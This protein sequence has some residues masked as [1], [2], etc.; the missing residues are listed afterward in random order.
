MIKKLEEISA[1]A[2]RDLETASTLDGLEQVRISVLGKKGALSE[3]LKTLGSV[4]AAERPAIGAAANEWKRKIEAAIETRKASLENAALQTQLER[5]RV[6]ISLPSRLPHRG[7][8]ES[9][10]TSSPGPRWKRI[11]S[12]SKLS[13]FRLIT[14][15]GTCR[16][17]FSWVPG[18]SFARIL[19]LFRC[20]R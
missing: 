15:P 14:Q 2:L 1:Q 16:T 18:S 6:D 19:R 9:A 5:D 7:S 20:G 4:P 3:V 10:L 11:F 13:I 12:I 8:L 17:R